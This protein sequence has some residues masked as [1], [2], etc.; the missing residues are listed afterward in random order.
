MPRKLAILA[1]VIVGLN[2]WVILALGTSSKGSFLTNLLQICSSWLAASLCFLARRRGRGVSRPFWLLVGCSMAAWG[3]ANVGWMYYE[4][5]LHTTAPRFSFVRIL[6]DVQGVFYAIALFLDN[7][8]DSQDFDWETLLDS[9]QIGLVFFSV[10][11][12]LYYVQLLQGA[13]PQA[14]ELVVT[15]ARSMEG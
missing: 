15:C 3:V 14:N 12:G 6:F 8:R 9:V 10:F 5:F 7:E 2:V 1:F 11:F 13:Y 4:N